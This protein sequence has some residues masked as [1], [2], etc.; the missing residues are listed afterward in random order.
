M[1][2]RMGR[3]RG[4]VEVELRVGRRVV[5]RRIFH[6]AEKADAEHIAP[7]LEFCPLVVV[8][9][10]ADPGVEQAG[11]LWGV[12]VEHRPRVA[13]L[14]SAKQLPVDWLG[15]EG[16]DA[17]VLCASRPEIHGDLDQNSPQWAALD[18][19]IRMGG[20]LVLSTG[21]ESEK[22]LADD[23]PLG[24]FA[25]GR[26][27][28]TVTLRQTGALESYG[29]GRVGVP[30]A[31]LAQTPLRAAR[32]SGVQ[33][34]V[35]AREADL[36]LVIRAARGLGQVL[37]L[38]VD[39]D[40]PPIGQWPDRAMLMARLLDLPPGDGEDID[41]AASAMHYGY[42]DLAGQLRSALDQFPGV[43]LAPF[44]VVA[45]LAAVYLLF[46]GPGDYFFLRKV[47]GRMTWTWLTFPM[48]VLTAGAGACGLAYWLKGNRLAAAQATLIDVDASSG[49][50]RGTAW[51]NLFCP[52]TQSFNLSVDPSATLEVRTWTGWLGL[53]GGG[54]GGMNPRTAEA[55]PW[56][57]PY[58]FSP[59]LDAMLGVP[60]ATWSSKSFTARWTAATEKFPAARLEEDNQL[61]VGSVPNT[62]DIPLERCLLAHG[63]SVYELG[64]LEPGQSVRVGA[65]LKRSE[66][67]TLLTGR[68]IVFV[69]SGDK[70]RQEVTPYDQSSDEV[71]YILQT[72][73]FYRAAG[74]RRYTG[75]W[76]DYQGFVD[77]SD[78]L[79]TDRAILFAWA[80]GDSTPGAKLLRDGRPLEAASRRHP[81]AFRVVYPVKRESGRRPLG[82]DH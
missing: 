47:T 54:I 15:Y 5:A 57:Q 7:G 44:W 42:R 62:L 56:A 79:K 1:L 63:R 73:M 30:P 24:R 59:P 61:L 19:W 29:G 65:A 78:L 40:R 27:E 10:D 38:A 71:A 70:F 18:Q 4:S 6:S 13:M 68:K 20:R 36:P 75:L 50:L 45:A 9:G 33:G 12:D 58:D 17:V 34:V 55:S 67:K 35:E 46:I 22:V 3:V 32:L 60:I 80:S 14:E 23:S 77:L 72:M 25:P 82:A 21:A 8:V 37:F 48:I 2:C 39:L 11:R 64:T 28:K 52:K 43:R 31:A 41:H 76:N 74:G 26:W 66:L 53:S 49:L 51:M 69:E 81:T 16:V